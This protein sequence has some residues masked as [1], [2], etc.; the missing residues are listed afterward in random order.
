MTKLNGKNT[1]ELAKST[2][3]LLAP[4]KDKVHAITSDDGTEF[5]RHQIIAK[6]LDVKFFFAHPYSSWERGLNEY[7]NKLIRQYIPK[8]TSFEDINHQNINKINLKINMRPRKKL[9][10]NSPLKVY[11]SIFD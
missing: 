4:Y 10:Y 1:D 9:K 7:T 2:I 8:K 3:R 5:T 11:L 6:K